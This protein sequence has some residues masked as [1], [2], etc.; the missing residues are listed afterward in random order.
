V[1]ARTF[2]NFPAPYIYLLMALAGSWMLTGVLFRPKRPSQFN[3]VAE[4]LLSAIVAGAWIIALRYAVRPWWYRMKP[5]GITAY[6]FFG[7]SKIM[8][9][10]ATWWKS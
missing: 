1:S 2:W 7:L 8:I 6:R 3:L 9:R 5:D 10:W 4:I